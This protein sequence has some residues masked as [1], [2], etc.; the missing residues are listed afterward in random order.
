[1]AN[2]YYNAAVDMEWDT[3]GNWWTN[4]S[5]TNPSAAIPADGDT[6]YLG[7]SLSVAPSTSVTLAHIYVAD[8]ST[9]GGQFSVSFSN[10]TGDVTLYDYS[11]ISGSIVGN[12]VFN[13]HSSINL[14]SSITGN[15]TFNDFSSSNIVTSISGNATFNDYSYNNSSVEG[16]VT[17]NDFSTMRNSFVTGD[18]TFDLTAAATQIIGGYNV[19]FNGDVVV[20]GGAGGGGSDN[21]IARLLD[22][23]WFINL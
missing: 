1:M 4:A 22:L 15:A 11:L 2:L 5:F 17:F 23:P 19:S 3:L 18:A 20:S 21:T 8:P 16:D 13:G 6:A 12:A 9:G 7:A 14:F 10:I